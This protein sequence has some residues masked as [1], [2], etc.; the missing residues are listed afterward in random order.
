MIEKNYLSVFLFSI[1]MITTPFSYAAKVFNGDFQTGDFSY[2]F[3]DVDGFGPPIEGMNDF[4]MVEP[5]AGNY[6]AR[7]EVDYRSIPGNLSSFNL[8]EALFS[9]ILYQQLDLNL[10]NPQDNLSLSFDWFFS[11]ETTA[12][13]DTFT[14]GLFHFGGN[15][16]DENGNPGFLI[17]TTDYGSGSF[18]ATLDSSYNNSLGWWLGFQLDVGLD[19]FGSF[20]TLD[21][22]ELSATPSTNEV[23]V[24][25]AFWLFGSAIFGL[26][27]ARKLSQK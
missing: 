21:N 16:F 24:P 22:I 18:S 20:I 4:S 5:V 7:I 14:V 26:I 12:A 13:N 19:G 9:N 15:Y 1:L 3:Q 2:W 17:N 11:G 8:D 27:R 6:A 25:G 10:T 23:P